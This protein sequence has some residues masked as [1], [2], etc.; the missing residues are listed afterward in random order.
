[1][2]NM[3]VTDVS[4]ASR[5][6][7][8]SQ[9]VEGVPR[10]HALARFVSSAPVRM[11]VG[12][13]AVA[14]ALVEIVSDVD[15]LPDLWQHLGAEHGLLLVG[16]FHCLQALGDLLDGIDETVEARKEA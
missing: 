10:R 4:D 7:S 2:K 14:G 3:P 12:L 16:L 5:A 9:P 15:E 8:R 6:A 13:S 1:M 11:F